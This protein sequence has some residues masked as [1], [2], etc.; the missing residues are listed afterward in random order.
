LEAGPNILG[1]K[2]WII[3]KNFSFGHSPTE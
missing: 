2:K 1:F 3:R